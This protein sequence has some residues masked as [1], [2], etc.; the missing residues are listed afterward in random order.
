MVKNPKPFFSAVPAHTKKVTV[1]SNAQ[2]AHKPIPIELLHQRL[3]HTKT[4]TLLYTSQNHCWSDAT[5]M[6]SPEKF[7][8]PCQIVT[9]RSNNRCK[10]PPSNPLEPGHTV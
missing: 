7:C 10:I 6:M 1:T 2:D 3:G 5:A 4:N 9:T 8:D